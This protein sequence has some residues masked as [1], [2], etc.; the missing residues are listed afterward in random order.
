M[1]ELTFNLVQQAK[2]KGGDKYLCESIPEFTI[3]IPQTISRKDGVAI[4]KLTIS[5]K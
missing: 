4:P 5:I 3:Y 2:S 1:P